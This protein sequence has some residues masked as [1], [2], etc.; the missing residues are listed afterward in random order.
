MRTFWRGLVRTIFWSYERMTWQYDLMVIAIVAFVLLAPRGWFHD[1]P[2]SHAF[3]TVGVELI[4][5]DSATQA[6]TYRIDAASLPQDKRATKWS[7]ELERRIHDVLGRS[8]DALKGRTFQLQHI[9]P[10]FASDGSVAAYDVT[11][12]F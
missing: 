9:E 4:S 11:V 12:H 3:A 5:E 2:K 10:V 7:P 8:V 6:W 1:Q